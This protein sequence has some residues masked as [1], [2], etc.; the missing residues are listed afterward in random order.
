MLICKLNKINRE[1]IFN[2]FFCYELCELFVLFGLTSCRLFVN[3]IL[4]GYNVYPSLNLQTSEAVLLIESINNSQ[5]I[6]MI[7]SLIERIFTL[8]FRYFTIYFLAN[9]KDIKKALFISIT[10]HS[11]FN[12]IGI[13]FINYV[14]SCIGRIIFLYWFSVICLILDESFIITIVFLLDRISIS[15]AKLSMLILF[16]FL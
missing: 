7:F 12:I 3:S 10:I 14:N 2:F 13:F 16:F 6:P 11:V 8:L 9:C 4:I 5:F 15:V 1:N